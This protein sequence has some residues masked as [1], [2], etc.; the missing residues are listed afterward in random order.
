MKY[1]KPLIFLLFLSFLLFTGMQC[2]KEET[3][4]NALPPATQEGKNTFGFLLNGEVWVP[5]TP[6]LK[7]RLDLTYDPGYLNGSFGII[8]NRY[9]SEKDIMELAIG[10]TGVNKTGTYQFSTAS[11]NIIYYDSKSNCYY[12]DDTTISGSLTITKLDLTNKFIS[13]TFNFKLVKSGCSIIDATEG[14]FDI[15]IE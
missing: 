5:K 6:L 15:K 4:I 8:A 3:G 7:Q 2:K 12:L 10:S 14:R 9:I 11:K 1:L 13:G